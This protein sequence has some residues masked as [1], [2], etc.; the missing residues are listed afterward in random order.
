VTVNA[1][2]WLSS[3]LIGVG[4]AYSQTSA[5]QGD[6]AARQRWNG[7]ALR[8]Y[9]FTYQ[10]VCDCHPEQLADT[11]VTVVDGRVTAV[12]YARDD[13]VED[14][15]V[16]EERVRWFRTIDDFFSLIENALDR[17]AVVRTSF[18]ATLGYP[19]EVY[20][21]YD[22]ELVG[23]EVDISITALQPTR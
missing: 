21:D 10:R 8:D 14:I 6:A 18:D 5:A 7:A 19:T 1:L 9:E 23:D 11:I 2:T 4:L 16:A 20:I 3:A 15:P 22:A 13:Y 17:G 12:R